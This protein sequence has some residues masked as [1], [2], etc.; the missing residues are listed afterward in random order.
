MRGAD[1]DEMAGAVVEQQ[2]VGPRRRAVGALGDEEI[3][4]AVRVH[5]DEVDVGRGRARQRGVGRKPEG[6]LDEEEILT[7]TVGCGADRAERRAAMLT[8][9]ID[10]TP[11]FMDNHLQKPR[12]YHPDRVV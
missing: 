2:T 8:T 7:G 9:S 6:F 1:V 3:E 5:V 4:I 12:L 10:F 11:V